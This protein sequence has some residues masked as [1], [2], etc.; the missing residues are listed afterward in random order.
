MNAGDRKTISTLNKPM[1]ITICRMSQFDHAQAQLLGYDGSTS[2][3]Y[4]AGATLNESIISWTGPNG[5]LT[6]NETLNYLFRSNTENGSIYANTETTARLFLPFGLCTT[7]LGLIK[8]I[9]LR[10]R[11]K[12]SF[13][14]KKNGNYVVFISD[15]SAT[16]HFQL[17]NP[18]LTGVSIRIEVSSNVITTSY[19]SIKIKERQVETGDGSCTKYPDQ[20]G[21][22]NYGDCVEDENRRRILPVLG[23]MVPWISSRDQCKAPLQRS[24]VH[25]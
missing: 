5:S 23:C 2:T 4:L 17:P 1:L 19:Y 15:P 11:N 18:L 8:D 24:R 20:A 22:A 16:V 14:L 3:P 21:H 25:I 13:Y 9:S 6:F 10:K 7:S 12:F